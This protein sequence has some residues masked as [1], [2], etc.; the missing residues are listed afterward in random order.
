MYYED[1]DLCARLLKG[2]HDLVVCPETSVVH[3]ARRTSPR[4]PKFMAW[5]LRSMMRYFTRYVGRLP[6]R[7]G[8]L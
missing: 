6:A 3:D 5:H 2:G 1:V 4:H 7:H 8:T